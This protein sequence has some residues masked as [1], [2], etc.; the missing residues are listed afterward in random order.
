MDSMLYEK[1]EKISTLKFIRGIVSN[2]IT[3]KEER[4]RRINLFNE[5]LQRK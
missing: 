5:V 3:S 2:V 1:E 4:F